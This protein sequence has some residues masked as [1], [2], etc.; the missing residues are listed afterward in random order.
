[1]NTTMNEPDAVVH[2]IEVVLSV[3]QAFEL[4]VNGMA[5]WWP[6][7]GHSCGGDDACGVR[8]E[9]RVGGTVTELTRSGAEHPWGRLTAWQPPAHFAMT[10]H[11]AQDAERATRLSVRFS[12][13]AGGCAVELRHD[14]WAVRGDQAV[15]IR[16]N[17]DQGWA[18]ALGRYAAAAASGDPT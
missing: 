3:E 11:P 4:F 9:P 5:R 15:P 1:M 7:A 12:A 16:D 17:Y 14:G 2:R 13:V 18:M 6:F 8:F 10:W